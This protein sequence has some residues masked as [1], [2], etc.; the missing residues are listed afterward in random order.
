MAEVTNY[1]SS[2]SNYSWTGIRT[3]NQMW[4]LFRV[5]EP[6]VVNRIDIVWGGYD[7]P[8]D[9][10]HFIAKINQ[11]GTLGGL[12][13][14]SGIIKVPQGRA[15]RTASVPDTYLEPGDYAVG[16]IGNYLGRRIAS[17]WNGRWQN[18]IYAGYTQS[19]NGNLKGQIWQRNGVIPCRL[20][21]QP[22]GR[23]AVN[24][25]GSYRKGQ[26]FVNVNGSWRRA[27]AVW[28]NVNGSWRRSR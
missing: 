28:V 16:F 3:L 9:G 23:I 14:R 11:D 18:L 8:T 2:K 17:T 19:L 6:I 5:T 20:Q 24:V 25:N 22:A 12:V 4:S 27:K 15:W 10:R 21:Y 26:A 1:T 13:V 7:K